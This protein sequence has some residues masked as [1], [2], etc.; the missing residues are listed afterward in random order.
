[1]AAS[2]N[3]TSF[4]VDAVDSIHLDGVPS[5]F[6]AADLAFLPESL[7]KKIL[8]SVQEALRDPARYTRNGNRCIISAQQLGLSPSTA[9]IA[10]RIIQASAEDSQ[11]RNQ[12]EAREAAKQ[13][14]ARFVGAIHQ[15]SAVSLASDLSSGVRNGMTMTAAKV[16]SAAA[17][18]LGTIGGVANLG[19]GA[20]LIRDGVDQIA[21]GIAHEDNA[22]QVRGALTLGVGI[23]LAVVGFAMVMV[24]GSAILGGLSL[25]LLIASSAAPLLVS[26]I[27]IMQSN[28]PNRSKYALLLGAIGVAVGMVVGALAGA[29]LP[30]LIASG[31][32]MY[33]FVFARACHAI[34]ETVALRNGLRAIIENRALTKRE[35]ANELQDFFAQKIGSDVQ[36]DTFVRQVGIDCALEAKALV[37][38]NKIIMLPGGDLES[39]FISCIESVAERINQATIAQITKQITLIAISIVGIL[40]MTLGLAPA[41]APVAAAFSFASN[42]LWIP[43]DQ[44]HVGDALGALGNRVYKAVQRNPEWFTTASAVSVRKP[45][46]PLLAPLDASPSMGLPLLIEEQSDENLHDEEAIESRQRYD[47]IMQRVAERSQRQPTPTPSPAT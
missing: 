10:R 9:F 5:P 40:G 35:R 3:S 24:F 33:V 28:L 18:I 39:E 27:L 43:V 6:T 7:R 4:R 45:V 42:V 14:E 16:A 31:V 30:L 19:A 12:V 47:E 46:Q 2:S 36:W 32:T 1:M 21:K 26:A 29:S 11:F 20:Y 13:D 37:K 15:R 44:Q 38:L 8:K 34:H 41:L 25:P 22:G 23:S 17:P